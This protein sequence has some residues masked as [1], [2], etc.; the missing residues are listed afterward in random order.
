[1]SQ[2]RPYSYE[3]AARASALDWDRYSLKLGGR[4]Q[5]LFSGEFHYWRVPDRSRWRELL[6]RYRMGG[7]NCVRIYFHWGY[8]CPR[9]G[10]AVWTG[11]RDVDYLLKLCTELGLYVLA[12]P[13]PYICAE[14]SA[15]GFPGWLLEKRR[16]RIRHLKGH[17][18]TEFDPE[19]QRYCNEWFAQFFP[20][21]APHEITRNPRGCVLGVQIENELMQNKLFSMKMDRY[22]EE[23]MLAARRA[24]S[25]VPFFHNDPWIEGSW[26]Q[27]RP[28]KAVTDLYGYDRYIIWC[29]REYPADRPPIWK[30]RDFERA[31]KG[32]ERKARQAGGAA[33]AG[34]ILIP[35]LQGGWFNQWGHD[36]GFDEIYDYYGDDYQKTLADSY[37]IQGVNI[38]S[39]YMYYGGT[40]WGTL[41]DPDVYTSYDYSAS[42][43]EFGFL[44]GRLAKLRKS[45]LFLRSFADELAESDAV[46]LDLAATPSGLVAGA[47]RSVNGTRFVLLRNFAN[48]SDDHFDLR[49]EPGVHLPLRLGRR[50]SFIAVGHLRLNDS[51][52][53]EMS[54]LPFLMRSVAQ[55]GETWVLEFNAGELLF[56]GAGFKLRGDGALVE[57]G[58]R[59]RV[60]YGGP[61]ASEIVHAPSG[62]KLTIVVLSPEDALTFSADPES[63]QA[64]WGAYGAA[65]APA[66]KLALELRG[67]SA[68][69]YLGR[70]KPRGFKP[71]THAILKDLKR[72]APKLQ[73]V[74]ESAPEVYGWE[75][76]RVDWS[77]D[78]DWKGVD[79]A[80]R[81]NPLDHGFHYGHVYYRVLF[82]AQG[83][84]AKLK[85]NT[86]HRAQIWLDGRAV[87][88]HITYG[89]KPWSAGAKN[90][91]DP[92]FRGAKTYA[93]SGRL[94]AN[95]RHELI[96]LT[97]NLGYN[98]GPFGIN[99]FRNP[100][101][102]LQAKL[103]GVAQERWSIGGVRA[104][105]TDPVFNTTALPGE[106][107]ALRPKKGDGFARLA[108]A[109]ALAPDDGL[110]WFRARFKL[111][112]K[113]H[114]HRPL[115]AKLSG[116]AVAHIFLNGVYCG[117]Y[118]G[119]FGPQTDFYLPEGLLVNGENQ[120]AI[121]AYAVAANSGF[122]LAILPYRIHR[123]SG[124]LAS[125]GEVFQ[126]ES[127]ELPLG[128]R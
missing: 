5:V 96:V 2:I 104:G 78:A 37:L 68:V 56:R 17:G 97:E 10:A 51:V 125:D 24:G 87:G 22:M 86:R 106:S 18:R 65:F 14:T 7:L 89:Y 103:S 82:T 61:G 62:F 117:R 38:L 40:N 100:R 110:V 111:A 64:V 79:I 57:Q 118:W 41:G 27:D 81:Q 60:Q 28:G 31:L 63:G 83:A 32:E 45:A 15:G 4:R 16:V 46:D 19:F 48:K 92:A 123:Q 99:D 53:L 49:I 88:G 116:R 75:R 29:P 94:E 33:A 58:D 1:M 76:R 23:L 35:E 126:S 122:G 52:M 71:A 13:G 114:L 113:P 70:A 127:I 93:L 69:Y 6:L 25:T 101:G 109:P 74:D 107:A 54:T 55:A 26:V 47:R 112:H 11:A 119:D 67:E 98:R 66:K 108:E 9:E 59:V 85:L 39:F 105:V 73:P 42:I 36:H 44:S 20:Q 77:N 80:A 72:F 128:G 34:P 30:E 120:L 3:R 8:H 115:R 102:I 84:R 43:R 124:N 12:S 121:A 21:I 50:A 91:P 95:E 90:G